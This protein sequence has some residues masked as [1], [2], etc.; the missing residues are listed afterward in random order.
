MGN[1]V[2]KI[3]RWRDETV[4]R[5][6]LARLDKRLLDDIGMVRGDIERVVR[7]LR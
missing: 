5:G 7:H 1:I 6:Q 3:R 2:R 4:S